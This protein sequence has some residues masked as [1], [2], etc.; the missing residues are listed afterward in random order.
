MVI[1]IASK[2]LAL[3]LFSTQIFGVEF[4]LAS[5]NPENLFDLNKDG[6]EY[7]EY[8][9]YFKEW[10]KKAFETKITNVAKVIND[11]NADIIVLEEIENK[12][13]L[14]QLI[15]KTKYK[16]FAFDKKPKSAIGI[17]VLSKF[18]I[19]SKEI[20]EVDNNAPFERNILKTNIQ[21]ENK[22]FVV[23]ANH[24]RSK[25]TTESKRVKYAIALQN[26]FKKTNQLD[27]YVIVGDLNSNYDEFVTFKYDDTLNDTAG[28]TGINQVLNTIQNGNFIQKEE[29]L[30]YPNSFH[31]NP[32][33]ELP[34]DDRYSTKFKGENNT[35][36]HIILSRTLFDK[37][38]IS[39]KPN[40]FKVFKNDYLFTK[41][42]VINRWNNKKKDGF[43]DHLPI[44]A[45]FTTDKITTKSQT[46]NQ[47]K[48][49]ESKPIKTI[50][51]LYEILTLNNNA[52]INNVLVTY[53]SSKLAVLKGEKNDRSILYYGDTSA[54]ELGYMYDIEV[55]EL[56]EYN[57]NKE[58][59][60]LQVLR[61]T[62]KVANFEKNFLNGSMIDLD[63]KKYQN[64]II[65]NLKGIYKK[66][67]LHFTNNKGEQK[68]KIYFKK[69][70]EKPKD[71]VYLEIKSGILAT[72][73]SKKQIVINKTE[74][75]KIFIKKT[76]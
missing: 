17:A 72:Y 29:I 60:K 47:I 48:Q 37:D 69:D 23:Y 3:L 71:G 65:S 63:D 54:L 24:W 18:P 28:I 25:K 10:D 32:W 73:K 9:P 58:I 27:D 20:I 75:Y 40:S 67:Y 4:K 50:K 51:E 1:R 36:D 55:L 70:M 64:E 31:F 6:T 59:K 15:S 7:K 30:N 44:I 52:K 22:K 12:A 49:A 53:K 41:R 14:L 13:V 62:L 16:Y 56:D 38:G 66:N 2:L 34:K 5:Y 33:L 68:I 74:D 43:S 46:N 26:Y 21:I 19:L 11:I 76:Y 8:I 39:Y 61:K 42:G 45:S 57:G 35:P